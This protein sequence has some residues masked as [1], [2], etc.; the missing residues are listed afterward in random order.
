MGV[1]SAFP[2]QKRATLLGVYV[3]NQPSLGRFHLSVCT[4][5]VPLFIASFK[6]RTENILTHQAGIL[7]VFERISHISDAALG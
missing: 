5:E 4:L 7:A 6:L 3:A 2:A 1:P